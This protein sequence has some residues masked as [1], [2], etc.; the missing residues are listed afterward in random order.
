M[1]FEPTKPIFRQIADH[2]CD[3]IML[4]RFNVGSRIPSVREYAVTLEVNANTVARSFEILQNEG[5]IVKDRGVGFFVADEA[6]DI[7]RQQRVARFNA[8]VLPNL[9]RQ[10]HILGISPDD[11]ARGY[12]RF[13][14]EEH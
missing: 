3:E 12:D 14:K 1:Y 9:F 10:M 8:E 11:I 5:I 2:I 13:L 6:P 7:I 4:R